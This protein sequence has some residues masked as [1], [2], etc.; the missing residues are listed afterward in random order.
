MEIWKPTHD[1]KYEVSNY[2]RVRNAKTGYVLKPQLMQSYFTVKLSDRKHKKIH[3]LVAEAFIV[4]PDKLPFVNHKDHDKTNNH[5]SN[6]EWV[7]N[8]QNMLHARE[9][10]DLKV[11]Q[12]Q[13]HEIK[14]STLPVKELA[15]LYNISQPYVY[16]ILSGEVRSEEYHGNY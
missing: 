8:S 1:V 2:G 3:R 15:E 10:R 13:V 7:N 11:T 14:A 9:N 12:A 5:I 4:N 6:L 16:K